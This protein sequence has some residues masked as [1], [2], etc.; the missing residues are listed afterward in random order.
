MHP[1]CKMMDEIKKILIEKFQLP[2]DQVLEFLADFSKGNSE[3]KD[4]N[5]LREQTVDFV[6][7][8]I[9]AD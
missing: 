7:K 8:T 2:E 3:P 5:D 6:Q 1:T 4:L 9:L